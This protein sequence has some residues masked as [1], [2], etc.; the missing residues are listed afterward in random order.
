[1]A[2]VG[3]EGA[4]GAVRR[5]AGPRPWAWVL[6]AVPA[7]LAVA[8][9]GRLH[10]DEV[11]QFLEPAYF[12]AHGYG[13]LAWEWRQGLRNWAAPLLLS[14]L[15]RIWSW[16]GIHDPWWARGRLAVPSGLR[17]GEGGGLSPRLSL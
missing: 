12:R 8:A 13:V 6:A 16:V 17:E 7:A 15:L 11:Y 5:W 2:C 9:L 3:K 1:G 4:A 14:V 10:P